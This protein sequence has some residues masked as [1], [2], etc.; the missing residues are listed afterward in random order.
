V[1]EEKK[2]KIFEK[3]VRRL[4]YIGEAGRW[5]AL[6]DSEC[7]MTL[8][9]EV[10]KAN[11]RDYMKEHHGYDIN[12]HLDTEPTRNLLLIIEGNTKDNS[13]KLLHAFESSNV[14]PSSKITD[15]QSFYI[16]SDDINFRGLG[17]RWKKL[18]RF[19]LFYVTAL[20]VLCYILS[21]LL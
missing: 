14:F 18:S 17:R 3:E 19:E 7:R 5:I 20:L 10:I 8:L 1:I 11:D 9:C 16:K 2:I 4:F 12:S 15:W 13:T 21:K 6:V